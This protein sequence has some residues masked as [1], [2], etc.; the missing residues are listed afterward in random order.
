VTSAVANLTVSGSLTISNNP[1]SITRQAGSNSM[2]AFRV[3][4]G[5]AQPISYQWFRVTQPGPPGTFVTNII[6]GAI[7]D[8]LWLSGLQSADDGSAYFARVTNAALFLSTNSGPATLTVV[9]RTVNVP[10]TGYARVVVADKPVAYWRLDEPDAS[11]TA[12]DAVGSFHGAYLANAGTFTYGAPNGI[13]NETNAAVGITGGAV[14]SVP[15]A[16]ELNPYGNW[17]AEIWL[18][19]SSLGTDGGDYRVVFSSQWNLFPNPYHGWYVYQQ[20]NHTFA[21]APQPGNFFI[22]A[23]PNDP[24]NGDLLVAGKWYHLVIT[25]DGV[26]F[27]VYVNGE[28]RGSLSTATAGFIPNGVNGD[29]SIQA[30]ATVLGR[31][32][33]SAFNPFLG[34]IDETAFYNYAL[35]PTQVQLHYLNSTKLTITKSGNNVVLTWPIGTL[36][37]APAASGTYTNV[38]GATSPLTNAASTTQK[39]YRVQILP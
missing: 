25:D 24:A 30:G 12:T 13:P 35:S 26:A 11:T 10:V 23:R 38:P 5:G 36:Q 2:A 16:L 1:F 17:S 8:T 27:R 34:T 21:L 18:K 6:A 19:P 29:P 4:A 32:T 31:R 33:D 22:Q 7:N 28:Q 15:Y 20:P 14:V 39:Y 9:P 3:V 37:S